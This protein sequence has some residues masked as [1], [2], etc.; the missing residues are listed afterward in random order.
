MLDKIIE[1]ARLYMPVAKTT[2][3]AMIT[4][5]ITVILHITLSNE[6]IAIQPWIVIKY[7][8]FFIIGILHAFLLEYNHHRFILHNKFNNFLQIFAKDHE[9]HHEVFRGKNFQTRD[10]QRVQKIAPYWPTFPIVFLLNYI[11][12]LIGN[13]IFGFS[14]LAILAI[15]TGI[16]SGFIY[17]EN[18]H[19]ALHIEGCPLNGTI[20][21]SKDKI[22]RHRIHHQMPDGYYGVTTG[23]FDKLFTTSKRH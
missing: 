15:L 10:M 12:I 1:E 16:T 8:P 20:F 21:N 23:F 3:I 17:F 22:Q 11:A 14:A 5:A 13:E 19:F 9:D 7:L 2:A 4:F 18:T 6:Q